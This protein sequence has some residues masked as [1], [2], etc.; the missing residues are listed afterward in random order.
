MAVVFS[1]PD[2]VKEDYLALC[3]PHEKAWVVFEGEN[4]YS[5]SE[6][7]ALAYTTFNNGNHNSEDRK[8]VV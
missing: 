7:Y 8:S 5:F 6:L 2:S 4:L 1:D 3:S